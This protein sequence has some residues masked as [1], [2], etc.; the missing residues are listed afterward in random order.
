MTLSEVEEV[1]G[2]IG[3]FRVKVRQ[4]ARYIDEKECTACGKCAE[5]C[6]VVV[7]DEFQQGFSS[8]KATYIPYPQA[9]PSAYLI[10]M[11]RCL[12]NNPV[13]C[14]KCVDAC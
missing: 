6:P 1:S 4:R 14:D 9:V 5:V 13:A 12:G 2:H 11:G 10:D 7:P 8:R 3:N